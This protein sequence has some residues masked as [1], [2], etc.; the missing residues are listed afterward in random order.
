MDQFPSHWVEFLDKNHL[1]GLSFCIPE[2]H[3]ASGIGADLKLMSLEDA[4]Q[5][6]N[7]FYPGIAAYPSGFIP[8]AMCSVGSDD[9]YF[10]LS[11]DN[12]PGPLYRIYH[13]SCSESGL[14]D[15]AIEVVLQSY[16]DLLS[17]IEA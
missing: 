9:P 5:E 2:E 17:Y 1:V 3:D 10:I 13:D 16:P 7:E 8:V 15:D 4:I 12:A 11:T 6:A 14:A